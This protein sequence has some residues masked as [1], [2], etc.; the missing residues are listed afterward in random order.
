VG[1]RDF[2]AGRAR[3]RNGVG[4][5]D[6]GVEA[7]RYGRSATLLAAGIGT[8]GVLTYLYFALASHNLSRAEYGQIVVLWSAVMITISIVYRPVEQLLSRT[9]AERQARTLPIGRPLRIGALIQ[10]G[11]AAAVAAATLLLHGPLETSVLEGKT[12]LY[13]VMLVS[14]VSFGASYYARGFLAGTRRFG[15]LAG[16]IVN[17]ATGRFLFSLAVAVGIA[18]GQAVVAAGIA[19]APLLSLVVVPLAF[20]GRARGRPA[21]PPADAPAAIA[22]E[23][24]FTLASGAGFAAAVLLIMLSEQTLINGG[25][26][27]VRA[28][29]GASA[30][31]FI[32]NVL[33]VARAPLLLFQGIATSLLPHLTRLRSRGGSSGEEAFRLSVRGTLGAI[34]LFTAAVSAVILVAGPKLMQIAFGAKFTYDRVG[35][36]CVS[37]G[38]GVYLAATTLNQASVA[39]GKVRRAA[40]CWVLCA[41]GFLGWNLL[42]VLSEFRRVEVGFLG[43]A[44]AL[45]GLL[46]VVYRRPVGRPAD[47][48]EPG[49]PAELEARL[50]AAEEVG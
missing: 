12:A 17:E 46:Y 30:A 8:A 25:P 37:A 44:L 29:V 41:L 27:L 36:L 7:R 35:L 28:S 3:S 11:I 40:A 48:L 18:S 49:S 6:A 4:K 33:M 22:A 5:S 19:V 43:A 20:V 42:P 26:L 15:L 38:M 34:A 24:E 9:I 2:T 31:G 50:A 13:W 23:Q 1:V 39:E 14:V 32:F 16:L 10:L 21:P 45:C 47:L